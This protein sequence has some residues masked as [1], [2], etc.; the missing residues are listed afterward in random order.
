MSYI[1]LFWQKCESDSHDD[2]R[3]LTSQTA[4]EP[5]STADQQ[6]QVRD[7]RD[8]IDQ[9]SQRATSL[10]S[11]LASRQRRLHALEK[12]LAAA[13][14]KVLDWKREANRKNIELARMRVRMQHVDGRVAELERR[15]AK[16]NEL[17]FLQSTASSTSSADCYQPGVRSGANGVRS[18]VSAV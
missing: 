9:Q 12:E 18:Q 13:E 15:I 10:E 7:L 16:Q 6:Q 14:G 5:R 17:L 2:T 4:S 8:V 11:E 3:R 1:N